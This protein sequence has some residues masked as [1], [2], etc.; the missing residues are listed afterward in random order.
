MAATAL[1][2]PLP[3]PSRLRHDI[4]RFPGHGPNPGA[5]LLDQLREQLQEGRAGIKEFFEAGGSAEVVHREL[6]RQMDALVQGTLD[7]ATARV[8]GSSNPTTGE[9]LAVVAVGGYG[10]QELAP[11]SDVDLLFLCPYKRT[12]HVEQVS[13]FLL[14]KLWDLGLKVGQSVRS[15]TETIKLA[16]ND[17]T[18]RTALLEARPLWGSARLFAQ[19]EKSFEREIVSGRA[20][21]FIE[22]KLAEREQRH[23]R[24]G[25]SRFLLEPNIK[26]G[27]GGLRDLQTLLWISR[28]L[29][30]SDDPGELVR[31]GLLTRQ[32]LSRFLH[33]RRFLWTVRCHLHYLT[34]R[35]EERLTFDVQPE[36]ARRM[37]YRERNRVRAVERFM[38][39]YYLVAKD[40]GALTRIFCAALEEKQQRPPRFGLP[41]FGLGRRKVNGFVVQGNRLNVGDSGLF[42][43]EPI[44]MLELFHFAQDRELDIHP[45]ALAAVANHL[46]RIDQRLREDPEANRLFLDMLCSRKDPALTLTRMNEAGVL[47]RFVP[48][49]GRIVAQM[50]HNLYHVYTVDEHTIRAIGILSQIEGGQLADELPIS[51][52]VMPK[53]LSR[54]ELYVATFL[55]DIAKGRGGDHSELGEQ[56]AKRLCPRFGLPDDAT[57]TVAWLVRNHLAMSRFAFKRDPEDPQTILDFV[58][59]VQ[60]P[61]RL[62]LL[63][64]LTATDI[65]AVGPN[66]WNG[67]KGQLLRELYH[68]AAAA[69]ATGDPQGRRGRRIE[70]A[71]ATL[72]EAL[73]ALPDWPWPAAAIEGYLARHDPR[74]WLGFPSEEHLRHAGIV[75]RADAEQLPLAVDFRIDEFRARSEVLL[76]AADH[77]GLFMKVAG[78]L[79]LSGVSIVDAHVFTTVDGMALD[80]LGFQ[81][82]GTRLAVADR[83]RLERIRENIEK[84]LRGEIWLEK[85][86]AGRRN[87][88]KRTDVFEVEPR[89]LVDNG[90]SR[91]HSVIEVNGRDR[92]GLLFE[93]AKTLKELG[94]VIHSAHV[95]TYGERVV[96]VFYVKD[97]FG[98]KI[99]HRSKMQRVQRQLAEV[100]A[101]R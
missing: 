100:L 93:L 36:I 27:K 82:A 40:V 81:D 13:E 69:M 83:T 85:A 99:T 71:K 70:R 91:T 58:S 49:F 17:L 34:G 10:R 26:E 39:R 24:M 4:A 16:Q 47:G 77:P 6:S 14:Y 57:E 97:V 96:D 42:E 80:T 11:G 5:G 8:Y 46:G 35:A 88:P 95:S 12:P 23:Q 55:H 63:L 65:R 66:V 3:D 72:A 7:F 38:K 76:Y 37:G 94:L 73:A 19:L 29:H 61:E 48:D 2:R 68:E 30:R 20:S 75:G 74:Y 67:W 1:E 44:R 25:D 9:E 59:V 33:A 92:P 50:Q 56:V 41:R 18:V 98:L 45:Q 90:A 21:A 22:S 15:I 79:A 62:K 64:V 101:A 60:S 51:T 87:L 32:S 43:R 52:E 28:F 84:A 86:L 53:L 89:V 31:Q 78:A 54:R